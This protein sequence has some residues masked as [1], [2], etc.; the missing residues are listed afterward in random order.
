MLKNVVKEEES[1]TVNVH[2]D[3]EFVACLGKTSSCQIVSALNFLFFSVS[4]CG[5]ATVSQVSC[6]GHF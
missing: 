6:F 2:R 3:L 5:D 1:Q 4:E